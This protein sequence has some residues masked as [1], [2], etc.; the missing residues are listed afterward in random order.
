MQILKNI[1]FLRIYAISLFFIPTIALV[2]SIFFH[3][4]LVSFNYATQYD[5][6]FKENITG[7]SVKFICNKD[8]DY[9]VTPDI[10][11]FKRQKTLDQCYLNKIRI[12]YLDEKGSLYNFKTSNDSIVKNYDSVINEADDNFILENYN[13]VVNDVENNNKIIFKKLVISNQINEKCIQNFFE[14]RIYKIFPNLYEKFYAYLQT[15]NIPLLGTANTVNPFIKGE[16]SISNIVKR[17]P[18]K[19]FFKPLIYLGSIIMICYWFYNN[20]VL[21]TLKSTNKNFIFFKLGILS[22][23]FLFLHTFFLGWTFENEILTKIRRTYIVFFILFEVLAQGF[24]LREI[25]SV[26]N[27]ISQFAN[28]SI[29]YLKML[30]IILISS[31]TFIILIILINYNLDSKIDYI[32]EWNYFLLLLIFYFLSFLLWKKPI[33]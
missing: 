9:C 15:E 3:N 28:V 8:N 12:S 13:F 5:Y 31:F 27:K 29:I 23:I 25:Y 32:L 22:A 17:F 26:K 4:Y 10:L 30:F 2:G 1:R 20:R 11:L 14:Y 18:I 24:L 33:K 7:N 21:R 19:Y 16:T 6:E